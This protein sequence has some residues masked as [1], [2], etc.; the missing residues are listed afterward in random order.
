MAKIEET[1]NSKQKM[2][3]LALAGTDEDKEFLQQ[4]VT[5][6][7]TQ[8]QQLRTEELQLRAK[9]LELLRQKPGESCW[10]QCCC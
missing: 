7:D 8:L 1:D 6:L 5:A 4:Q 2:L 9:E 10:I 3:E